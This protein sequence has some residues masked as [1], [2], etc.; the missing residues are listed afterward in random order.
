MAKILALE[1]IDIKAFR[2]LYEWNSEF[3]G[4]IKQLKEVET[5]LDDD[6]ELDENYKLWK[7]QGLSVGLRV[8]LRISLKW[9]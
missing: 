6:K 7:I 5:C 2:K 1:T 9:I 8:N 4:E 3:D